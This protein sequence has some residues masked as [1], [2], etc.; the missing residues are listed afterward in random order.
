MEPW[1]QRLRNLLDAGTSR[2]LTDAGLIKATGA[3]QPSVWQ[4]FNEPE[5]KTFTKMIG[6]DL[7][8]R[9]AAYVGTS[10]EFLMTGKEPR[11]MSHS[12]RLDVDILT[13]ALEVS[14]DSKGGVNAEKVAKAYEL[15]FERRKRLASAPIASFPP[16]K[17]GVGSEKNVT[18]AGRDKRAIAASGRKGNR[19]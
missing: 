11:S 18:D 17:T 9:A 6:A 15:E 4:W 3:K 19:K 12:S 1:A 14:V 5:G 7:C 13:A 8:V 16:T 10:A 2:G